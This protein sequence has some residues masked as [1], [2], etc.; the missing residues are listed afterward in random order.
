MLSK[1]LPAG[2]ADAANSNSECNSSRNA[3]PLIRAIA[4][5]ASKAL[6]SGLTSAAVTGLGWWLP[7]VILAAHPAS[8]ADDQVLLS[9]V[10]ALGI[11]LV[12]LGMIHPLDQEFAAE[13]LR[14]LEQVVVVHQPRPEADR[15]FG[16]GKSSRRNLP[17]YDPLAWAI[18]SVHCSGLVRKPSASTSTGASAIR[19]MVMSSSS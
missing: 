5:N 16:R 1:S 10:G 4:P 6:I 8:A 14:G 3:F 19:V 15:P 2:N 17:V 13:A 12:K 9:Q 11:R 18:C 7:P